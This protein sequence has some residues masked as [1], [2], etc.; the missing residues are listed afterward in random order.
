MQAQLADLRGQ[1]AGLRAQWQGL[2]RQLDQMLQNN[3]ARPG[4]Q[5]QW[6]DVGVQLAKVNGQIATLQAQIA[7]KE[8]NVLPGSIQNL[9]N[10]RRNGPDPDLVV[11]GTIA[12]ALV[13]GFPIALAF[14]R[15]IWRGRPQPIAPRTDDISPRL[16]RLE[17][18][19]DAVAIEIERISEGQRFVTRILAERPAQARE[20]AA[21]SPEAKP[22]ALG[23]G[24]AEPVRVDRAAAERAP[25]PKR[26]VLD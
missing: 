26:G 9:P 5:Q 18:A 19:V 7:V 13:I 1:E 2:K 10:F 16:E 24:P 23:A 21:Q 8:G 11:G 14:A 20:A 6:A 12:F 4:V 3:P 25:V 22:L 17:Q 15:R